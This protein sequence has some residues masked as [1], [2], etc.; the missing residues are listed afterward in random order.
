MSENPLRPLP[1]T[2]TLIAIAFMV[3]A[4]STLVHEGL[5]HGGACVLVGGAPVVMSSVHFDCND[6]GVG[7]GGRRIIAA[8]GTIANFAVGFLLWGALRGMRQSP[9][10]WR[11]A[12]WLGMTVNLF[13][14]AGYFLF[15]G[16]GNIGDWAEVF[17]GLSPGWAWRGGL[18][19][20]GAV[21]YFAFILLSLHEMGS[22]VG[23]GEDRIRRA[24]RLA[25]TP[26]L[27]GGTLSCV[28]GMLNPVG[29]VLVA[30]S[31]AAASFGG[32]S[33]LA[34]MSELPGH[35]IAPRTEPPV[36]LDRR[37]SWILAGAILAALYVVVLGPGVRFR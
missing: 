14:A 35:R 6:T 27:A 18:V 4:L 12:L 13:Q 9:A 37:W 25:V 23:G 29:M 11:Y 8:G 1:D 10:H 28:A 33:G 30:I 36:M 24:R 2:L 21:L 26:Y 5:G 34:W 7:P 3:Y 16:A 32:T 17:Q 19:V 22:F 31:A 15:S 20:A